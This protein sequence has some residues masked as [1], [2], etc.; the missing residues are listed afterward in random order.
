M[1][2]VDCVFQSRTDHM[3]IDHCRFWAVVPIMADVS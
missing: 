3:S 2:G 1:K